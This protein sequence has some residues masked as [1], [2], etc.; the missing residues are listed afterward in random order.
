MALAKKHDQLPLD[1]GQLYAADITGAILAFL[2]HYGYTVWRQNTT[3]IYDAAKAR[4]RVNPQ[5]RRGV[6]D[7][8]GFR[9]RDGLFIGVEVKAGRDQLRDDQRTFLNELRAAGGLAFVAH[10]FAQ[11][12]QSFELRGLHC[13]VV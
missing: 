4:W 12:Q 2:T 1:L 10:D 5:S 9:N 7:I 11:F 8:I 6:P 13:Q 3:G